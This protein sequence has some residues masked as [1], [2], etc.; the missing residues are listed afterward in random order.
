MSAAIPQGP[1]STK[2]LA[3]QP[4][5]A[6]LQGYDLPEWSHLS[7]SD[8]E[9]YTAMLAPLVEQAFRAPPNGGDAK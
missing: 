3:I 9:R 4:D 2:L 5:Y 1:C 6:Q 8:A 7:G